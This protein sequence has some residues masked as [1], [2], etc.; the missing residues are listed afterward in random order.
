MTTAKATYTQPIGTNTAFADAVLTDLGAPITS[1]NQT[2]ILQ[3]MASE[4]NPNTWTGTAGAN[5]PLNNGYGS[6]GGAG[7]G[8]YPNLQTAA[9]DVAANLSAGNYGYGSIVQDLQNSASPSQ[10]A[11]AIQQS[12]WAG[13]H[14]GY[15]SAWHTAAV[16]TV[17][18]AQSALNGASGP[19][20]NNGQIYQT[21]TPSAGLSGGVDKTGSSSSGGSGSATLLNT[22]VGAI[23]APHGLGT[24]IVLVLLGI[25]VLGIGLNKIFSKGQAPSTVVL[26]GFSSTVGQA[27]KAGKMASAG[28]GRG[29]TPFSQNKTSPSRSNGNTQPFRRNGVGGMVK[30]S[31]STAAKVGEEAA[32]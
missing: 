29:N 18:T 32:V 28:G 7:L 8:S 30:E 3:W 1:N 27:K 9:Y 4:N 22:P 26:G 5:N 25:L 31:A 23:S 12:S 2:S 20:N 19:V 6:G 17:T 21:S 11:Q 16:P 10:T 15:G 14:Y 24:R 13:S